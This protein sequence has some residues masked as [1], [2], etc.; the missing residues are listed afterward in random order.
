MG[1]VPAADLQDRAARDPGTNGKGSVSPTLV[2]DRHPG[3]HR[4]AG[5]VPRD[6]LRALART[7]LMCW[8]RAWQ[9]TFVA[10]PATWGSLAENRT[11]IG[12][13]AKTCVEKGRCPGVLRNY[14]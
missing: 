7:G 2:P 10:Q 8:R 11:R 1:R 9:L 13:T 4:K 6:W 14:S 3:D 12:E 5:S